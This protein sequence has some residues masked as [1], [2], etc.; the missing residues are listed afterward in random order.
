MYF[1]V[2]GPKRPAVR[3]AW[4]YLEP[5]SAFAVIAGHIAFYAALMDACYVGDE[6]FV[7][8]A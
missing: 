3:A 4:A 6:S 5:S 1:D 7:A 8:L 2:V